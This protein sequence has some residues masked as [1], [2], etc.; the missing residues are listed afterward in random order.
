MSPIDIWPPFGLRVR[1]PRIELRYPND[2]EI[3]ELAD[4]SAVVGIHDPASMPFAIAWT[5]VPPPQQQRNTL[6]FH[7]NTRASWQP[8]DWSC[9]F[10][11]IVD[12]EIVGSQGAQAT[13]FNVLRSAVTGSFLLI[14]HQRRGIGKEMRAA[15]LHLL[16]AG[17]SAEWAETAAFEDNE[18]SLAVTRSLGYTLEGRH[19]MLSR[20]RAREQLAFRMPREA[21]QRQQRDDIEIIGLEPCLEMFGAAARAADA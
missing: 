5:D 10:V 8:S 21:W 16:F 7:W 15:I 2:E 3:A 12:G 13:N 11:V 17:L 9:N 14:S 1:T 20:G 6:Q 18:A 4:R 19:R